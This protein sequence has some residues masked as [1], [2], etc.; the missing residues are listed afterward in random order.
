MALL[1]IVASVH[2]ANAL[3][4]PDSW[5]CYGPVSDLPIQAWCSL[6]GRNG[7]DVS[8]FYRMRDIEETPGPR[9]RRF[10]QAGA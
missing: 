10:L 7:S 9:E 3:G 5:A 6:R 2:A 1:G 8:D 4:R